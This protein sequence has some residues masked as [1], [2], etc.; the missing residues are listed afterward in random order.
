MALSVPLAVLWRQDNRFYG[1][2]DASIGYREEIE[3]VGTVS[4]VHGQ[5]FVFDAYCF[6]TVP[7]LLRRSGQFTV[8]CQFLMRVLCLEKSQV[9]ANR[10]FVLSVPVDKKE[11]SVIEEY[12]LV[13]DSPSDKIA[14]EN[15]ILML[16]RTH[17]KT[18]E[19]G[20]SIAREE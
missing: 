8:V 11:G 15:T 19:V 5:L 3:H 9:E 7:N 20:V 13:F 4:S 10:I 17:L 16:Q 14:C 1:S 6:F 12:S 18:Q 2:F